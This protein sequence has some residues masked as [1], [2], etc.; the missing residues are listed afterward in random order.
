[1]R[2]QADLSIIWKEVE[3]HCDSIATKSTQQNQMGM[4][5]GIAKDMGWEVPK[6]FLE[7]EMSR[8]EA[9]QK[10][11]SRREASRED[12]ASAMK[13][14]DGKY[15][16]IELMRER[17]DRLTKEVE[18]EKN[19]FESEEKAYKCMLLALFAY[20]GLRPQDWLVSFAHSESEATETLPTPIHGTIGTYHGGVLRLWSG[21]T[22]QDGKLRTIKLHPNLIESIEL[23]HNLIGRESAY[24]L[25]QKDD[26]TKPQS[27][28]GLRKFNQRHHHPKMNSTLYRHLF[29][30]YMRQTNPD[31]TYKMPL[32]E[33]YRLA[34]EMGH[35]YKTGTE[36]Y[37]YLYKKI[38]DANSNGPIKQDSGS[39]ETKAQEES[40]SDQAS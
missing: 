39:E 8:R 25:P 14:G 33:Q 10:E 20:R 1:M 3:Q 37:S 13:C 32:D 31:G 6:S 40:V 7:K 18:L 5:K 9:L 15:L 19:P 22:N 24:L 21:K 34:N 35:T 11:N 38:Y 26:I 2:T 36:L 12:I 17:V 28:G 4:M 27:A 29:N 30:T 23:Y 16:T